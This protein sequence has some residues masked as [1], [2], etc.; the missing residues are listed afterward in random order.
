MSSVPG[1]LP[2]RILVTGVW[3]DTEATETHKVVPVVKS[4]PACG[5]ATVRAVGMLI[6][7]HAPT[8]RLDTRCEDTIQ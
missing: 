5:W 7:H 1:F 3:R 8:L 4:V 6:S 2:A